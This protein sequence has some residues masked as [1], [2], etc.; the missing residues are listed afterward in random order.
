MSEFEVLSNALCI[1]GES[2]LWDAENRVLHYVD[3]HG[4]RIRH[5]D[6]STG[7]VTDEVM[8]QQTGALVSARDGSLLACMED[9]VYKLAGNGATRP[10]F[11]P[12]PLLGMRF[13]DAKAGPDGALWG[14]TISYEGNG[15]LYRIA[16]D[17]AMTLLRNHVG[18]SNGLDWD[19]ARNFFYFNDT[20]TM[21]T[22]RFRYDPET[23]ALSGREAVRRFS[24]EEGNPD[25]MTLDA[26][27]MLWVAL[28]G[29]GKA[30]RIDP[31]DG[32]TLR[33]IRLPASNVACCAFAGDDLCDLV[34]TTAAH[35]TNLRQE[36][37]AGALFRV[38]TDVPGRAVFRFG[39]KGAKP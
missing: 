15:A 25:G 9:G 26:E 34:I 38:R 30:V 13:N 19:T 8:V 23:G 39:A 22:A 10:L 11:A 27:G 5:L 35:N 2:P 36:P 21:E 6:Y 1:V 18:N 20:P 17:G 3:I 4:R 32:R 16:P 33:E 14:G 24:P 37:L 7:K 12:L 28:W 31:A 29:H